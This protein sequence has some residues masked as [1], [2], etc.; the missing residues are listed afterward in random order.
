MS[1]QNL[2]QIRFGVHRS[3]NESNANS[4]EPGACSKEETEY[5]NHLL[6]F[7][8]A[9]LWPYNSYQTACPRPIL[10]GQHH[11]RLLQD[12]SEALIVAITDIVERWWTDDE[13]NLSRRMPLEKGEEDILKWIDDQVSHDSI[14]KYR[15]CLG[16]WRPDFLVHMDANG[17]E[18]FQITEIN[19]RF[20]FNGLMHWAYGQA[21]LQQKLGWTSMLV[22]ATDPEKVLQRSFSL[23][24]PK[25]PLHLLKGAEQGID[26]HMFIHEVEKRFGTKPRLITPADLRL[27]P[28]SS[29]V[30]GYRLCCVVKSAAHRTSP[31]G[32]WTTDPQSGEIW[33]EV[34]QVGLELHQRELMGLDHELLRQISLRCFNDLRTILLVH[35]KRMLGIVREEAP[36]LLARGVLMTGQADSLRSGIA[37]TLLPGSERLCDLLQAC[38]ASP[39]RKDGYILKP[40]RSGKGDGIV[41]G[42]ELDHTVWI[43]ALDALSSP[44]LR[45]SSPYVVQRRI[46]HRLYDMVSK[47]SV[48]R[49]RYPLVGTFHIIN[50][51]LLGLGIW[52]ASGERIVAISS[53]GSWMCSVMF[54][55]QVNWLFRGHTKIGA[56]LIA[57]LVRI[58]SI[59]T[60]AWMFI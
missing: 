33:E 26:I 52:R 36:R 5:H 48:G 22:H 56:R 20:P 38:R 42:D 44:R 10:V 6:D 59:F 39:Q 41:F 57:S 13:A 24:Q 47:D 30:G 54:Q 25:Y 37:E 53:G 14:A 8:P 60:P 46:I 19:A 27:L 7:C 23:F 58:F 18:R 15:H 3:S 12:L 4:I 29:L 16:S 43:S 45:L 50:G 34:Q 32:Y 21:V 28:D 2:A 11:Q 31:P 9:G 51:K 17:K 49:I 55:A 40:I 1:A 35:D